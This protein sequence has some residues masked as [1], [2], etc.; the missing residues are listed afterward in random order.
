MMKKLAEVIAIFIF[1]LACCLV[2]TL[3]DSAHSLVVN[4]YTYVT[5]KVEADITVAVISDLHEMEFGE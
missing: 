4:E 2:A 1:G 5:D 3:W